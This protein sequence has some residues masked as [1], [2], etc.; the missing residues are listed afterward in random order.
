MSGWDWER[1][2]AKSR[3]GQR[4]CLVKLREVFGETTQQTFTAILPMGYGKSHLMRAAAMGMIRDGQ[5]SA[6]FVIAPGET[7]VDQM[8]EI[9]NMRE[10]QSLFELGFTPD[11]RRVV[12][13][14]ANFIA[15]GEHLRAMTQQWLLMNIDFV[16]RFVRWT[17]QEFGVAPVFL[18][19]ECHNT[20][21]VNKWGNSVT[22]L[23]EAGARLVLVTATAYRSDAELIPGFAIDEISAE[24]ITRTKTRWDEDREQLLRDYF[25]GERKFIRLKADFEYTLHEALQEKPSPVCLIT[26]VPIDVRLEHVKDG[27]EYRLSEMPASRVRSSLGQWVR[28]EQVIRPCINE[29]LLWLDKYRRAG[30]EVGAIV[31][32][33][34][35]QGDGVANAH[36]KDIE[37]IIGELAP[38]LI[39]EIATMAD[40]ENG[41]SAAARDTIKRFAGTKERPGRGDVLLVKQMGGQGLDSARVKIVVD[42][43]ATRTPN[44]LIQRIGRCN[45]P[46]LDIRNGLYITPDDAISRGIFG[47]WIEDEGGALPLDDLELERTEIVQDTESE[48]QQAAIFMVTGTNLSSMNDVLG[49]VADA[50]MRPRITAMLDKYPFLLSSVTPPQL[51][52]M[53]PDFNIGGSSP[54]QSTDHLTPSAPRLTSERI[55]EYR[56]ALT[57]AIKDFV[58]IC[59]TKPVGTD[60]KTFNLWYGKTT[61]MVWTKVKDAAGVST[62]LSLDKITDLDDLERML[63]VCAEL[64]WG[65]SSNAAD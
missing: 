15:N 60:T 3:P 2:Y 62:D 28:S 65:S 18:I 54:E 47:R 43:S 58:K 53:A 39:V 36:A 20:S 38:E 9:S 14:E 27:S 16:L 13:Q 25:A 59:P 8:V 57:A 21:K 64:Q 35:D 33:G 45:R 29:M 41:G 7:L 55:P 37:R 10:F 44:S 5:A 22:Q 46:Y 19:D 1:I 23:L 42:L 26:R 61:A 52:I 32:C 12:S 49:N 56:E 6:A 48:P 31:F 24:P 30:T 63:S 11:G 17:Q 34:N 50:D 4:N 51:A 40:A